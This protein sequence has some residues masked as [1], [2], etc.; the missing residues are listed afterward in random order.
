MA[1]PVHRLN[2]RF[3]GEIEYGKR[4]YGAPFALPGDLVQFR[5][6]RRRKKSFQ[7]VH[8]ERADDYSDEIKKILAEPFCEYYSKCGGCRGQH[9]QYQY[10][11]DLKC[12]PIEKMMYDAFSV[13][14]KRIE[15]PALSAHRHRMDFVVDGQIMGQRPAADHSKFISIHEC[16]VQGPFANQA[17]EIMQVSIQEYKQIPWSRQ[18][19]T[20]I[21]KYV[22]IRSN[23]K[24]GL[25]ILTLITEYE[26]N[27]EFAAWLDFVLNHVKQILP[28]FG[29]VVCESE[30]NSEVSAPPGGK[31]VLGV[32][33][34]TETL[35]GMNFQVAY[36]SFFQPNPAAFDL[37]LE[38]LFQVMDDTIP[39]T[40]S[41]GLIDLYCG[42]AVLSSI[43]TDRYQESFK[44]VAGFESVQSAIQNAKKNL[45]HFSGE[46]RFYVQDLNQASAE[47]EKVLDEPC[48]LIVVDP[49]RA[50]M[51]PK[52]SHK[53]SQIKHIPWLLYISCNPVTQIRDLEIMKSAWIVQ[54]A[55]LAD[56]YPQTPHLEQAVFLRN[57]SL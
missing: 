23:K 1:L 7:V 22:T 54:S 42:N 5:L 21:L 28:E 48:N 46:A 33:L 2:S 24:S 26:K 39:E 31:A 6:N 18:L 45:Q 51:N 38:K 37:L 15:A 19:Q 9:L 34:Y 4:L 36:D 8:I 29:V 40:I 35:A 47:L 20:G 27:P 16:P 50:G 53:L 52:I 17:L 3:E 12:S 11:L 57:R 49:P 25:V 44:R 13:H 55:F 30:T 14:T 43:L 56:C 41:S 10:Q 32:A